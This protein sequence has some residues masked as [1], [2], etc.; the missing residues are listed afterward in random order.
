MVL[1]MMVVVASVA[2]VVKEVMMVLIYPIVVTVSATLQGDDVIAAGPHGTHNVV[3][4]V[5][6]IRDMF[7]VVVVVVDVTAVAIPFL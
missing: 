7:V 2:V 5:T 1:V 6:S 4:T 3:L